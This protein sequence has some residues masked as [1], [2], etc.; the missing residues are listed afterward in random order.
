MSEVADD[1]VSDAGAP[2]AGL[3]DTPLLKIRASAADALAGSVTKAAGED[4]ASRLPLSFQRLFRLGP[5][6]ALLAGLIGFAG[7]ASAYFSGGQVPYLARGPQLEAAGGPQSGGEPAEILRTVHQMADEIRV[8]KTSAEAMRG[9]Q[10]LSAKETIALEAY[11][12]RL[13]AVK[14]GMD[15]AIVE[16]G[17]KVDRLQREFTAKLAQM[18]ERYDRADQRPAAAAKKQARARRGDAFDPT[19]NPGAPGAPRPLGTLAPAAKGAAQN[20]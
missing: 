4:S 10:G 14:A 9:A 17:G 7:V 5:R 20:F 6:P 12:A 13:D 16:L 18:S 3:S 19:Q 11:K 15:A 2:D 1:A 8:L